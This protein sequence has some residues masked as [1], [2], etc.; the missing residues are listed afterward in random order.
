MC[1]EKGEGE[2]GGRNASRGW[3][4]LVFLLVVHYALFFKMSAKDMEEVGAVGVKVTGSLGSCCLFSEDSVVPDDDC[5]GE[6][7]KEEM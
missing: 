5:G 7:R 1:K 4:F 6:G 3:G 2:R